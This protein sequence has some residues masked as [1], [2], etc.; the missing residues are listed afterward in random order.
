MQAN[1]KIKMVNMI[2]NYVPQKFQEHEGKWYCSD[3]PEHQVSLPGSQSC[4]TC[5]KGKR[6]SDDRVGECVDCL[7]GSVTRSSSQYECTMCPEGKSSTYPFQTCD[8]CPPG[9]HT[10][11]KSDI[12]SECKACDI[13]MYITYFGGDSSL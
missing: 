2:A 13:G 11:Y 1:F 3:C 10:V 12:E 4:K 6:I 8:D 7:P 5:S 9:A